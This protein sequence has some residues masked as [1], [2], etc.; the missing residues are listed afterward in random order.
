MFKVTF[1]HG[2]YTTAWLKDSIYCP[3]FKIFFFMNYQGKKH[4]P[5]ESSPAIGLACPCLHTQ[6]TLVSKILGSQCQICKS[7][8]KAL[9]S[10]HHYN[11]KTRIS[12]GRQTILLQ[13]HFGGW[14]FIICQASLIGLHIIL[15]HS[16]QKL[17]FH[18]ILLYHSVSNLQNEF[19]STCKQSLLFK[20]NVMIR[21]GNISL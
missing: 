18:T 19:V 7:A 21:K 9:L 16:H 2:N 4:L 10:T 8:I 20:Q 3:S 6:I 11:Q 5:D 13:S 1:F 17:I 14:S 12:A 15:L